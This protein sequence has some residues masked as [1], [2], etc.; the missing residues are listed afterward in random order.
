MQKYVKEKILKINIE[1]KMPFVFSNYSTSINENA[2]Y[3]GVTQGGHS[4]STIEALKKVNNT[5][6]IINIQEVF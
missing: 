5:K 2:L 4:F 3:I 1:M 6:R